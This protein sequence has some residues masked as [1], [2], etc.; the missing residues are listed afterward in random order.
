[1]VVFG[2]LA[3]T[4]IAV[5]R[6]SIPVDASAGGWRY[7]SD[8]LEFA[9][10]GS[11]PSTVLQWGALHAPAISKLGANSFDAGLSFVLRDHPFSA[12][13]A[14]LWISAV[15]FAAG[16]FALG[17]ELGLRWCAAALPLLALTD[18]AWP[19]ASCSMGTS[20]TKLTFFQTEDSGRMCAL[21]AALVLA[22]A[23]AA[24]ATP[25]PACPGPSGR[26]R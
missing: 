22:R 14:A 19:G 16:M 25:A 17:W 8:G 6:L 9:D 1:V 23:A 2:L 7:W 13:A 3:V 4:A 18:H 24:A 15:G 21:L 12:M 5:A 10:A 26:P 20:F 11:V